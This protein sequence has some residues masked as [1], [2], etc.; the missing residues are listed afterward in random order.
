V[1]RLSR[2]ELAA[3]PALAEQLDDFHVDDVVVRRAV[4]D[5][6]TDARWTYGEYGDASHGDWCEHCFPAQYNDLDEPPPPPTFPA[7]TIDPEELVLLVALQEATGRRLCDYYSQMGAAPLWVVTSYGLWIECPHCKG[8]VT[9]SYDAPEWRGTHCDHCGGPMAVR[10]RADDLGRR[11]GDE[12]RKPA[13]LWESFVPRSWG[14]AVS[15]ERRLLAPDR[16]ALDS[17]E[18][19]S[20][21]SINGRGW[22]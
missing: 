4:D 9:L 19:Q 17:H 3:R 7:P 5:V 16:A 20:P 11:W 15:Q 10:L 12:P 22:S 13:V 1:R 18:A 2:Q 21:A 6:T 14:F 8:D